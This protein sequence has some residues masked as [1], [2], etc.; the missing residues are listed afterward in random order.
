[1]IKGIDISNYQRNAYK[2]YIDT[3]G[4]DFVITRA[5]WR[6][7]VDPMCDVMYQYAKSQ[8]KKLGIYFFPLTSDGDPETHAEWAYKQVLGY[9]NVAIPILDWEAYNGSEGSND[10]SQV[11]WAL[12]W[13]KKFEQL[14]G[15][16]PMIYMNSYCNSIYN[17]QPVVDNNNGLWIANYGINS[18]VDNGRPS[19]KYWYAAAM[20]QYTSRGDNGSSLDKNTFYGDRSAW[21]KYAMSSKAQTADKPQPAPIVKTYTEDEVKVILQSAE[22]KYQQQI[23][24]ALQKARV[25]TEKLTFCETTV[26][27][28]K[29]GIKAVMDYEN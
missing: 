22:N 11:Q 18:G 2:Y 9:I 20:H 27:K 13:L 15:V 19:V 6:Y 23:D 28:A 21:D 3:Y 29:E 10:P 8:G 14:S 25:A 12:R 7:S 17:W 5:A 26:N 24:E 4:T 1:M 16:K